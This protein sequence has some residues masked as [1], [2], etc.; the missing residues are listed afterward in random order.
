MKNAETN[1][2]IWIRTRL[3]NDTYSTQYS[4]STFFLWTI[5]TSVVDVFTESGTWTKREGFSNALV[6]VWGGGGAGGTRLESITFDAITPLT[7]TDTTQDGLRRINYGL[8]WYVKCNYNNNIAVSQDG[9]VWSV[10][11]FDTDEVIANAVVLKR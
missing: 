6:E 5:G 10:V 11:A 2:T 9:R 8:G 1:Q 3:R 4:G 7:G